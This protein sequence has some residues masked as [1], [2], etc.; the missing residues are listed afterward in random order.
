MVELKVKREIIYLGIL[1]FSLIGGVTII[2]SC[3]KE[4]RIDEQ[5]GGNTLTDISSLPQSEQAEVIQLQDS[6]LGEAGLISDTELN[7]AI[8]EASLE[9]F[10]ILTARAPIL[11]KYE[12]D[13]EEA[14]VKQEIDKELSINQI[15][16][17]FTS[18][19]IAQ[20]FEIIEQRFKDAD[21]LGE[22]YS[23]LLRKMV[24][25]SWILSCKTQNKLQS[26]CLA[27]QMSNCE[28]KILGCDLDDYSVSGTI[29]VSLNGSLQENNY[30]FSVSVF[31]VKLEKGDKSITFYGGQV[32]GEIA[33]DSTAKTGSIKIESR[34]MNVSDTE[35]GVEI[36]G[37]VKHQTQLSS[38]GVSVTRTFEN[39]KYKKDGKTFTIEGGKITAERKFGSPNL[40]IKVENLEVNTDDNEQLTLSG[41][42]KREVSKDPKFVLKEVLSQISFSS[43][44]TS[45]S[46]EF[47][48]FKKVQKESTQDDRTFSISITNYVKINDKVI[49]LYSHNLTI[50]KEG[51]GEFKVS[52]EIKI[53]KKDGT[54]IQIK[55]ENVKVVKGCQ[56]LT[57][58]TISADVKRNGKVAKVKATLSQNCSCEHEVEVEKD[59][60]LI[61]SNGNVCEAKKKVGKET[62]EDMMEEGKGMGM[63]YGS[64][65]HND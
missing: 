16:K 42:F 18:V 56:N 38:Y 47:Y 44:A 21:R 63:M 1:V 48:R 61:K 60:K 32:L 13:D 45:F 24:S 36:S 51:A 22:K 35:E 53:V 11:P 46:A 65:H 41:S 5:Q 40:T 17:N 26:S 6:L 49:K 19:E 59:G 39:I 29:N 10:N 20:K 4:T 62:M 64:Y 33:I 9:E 43:S 28:I 54:E 25:A 27:T 3:A 50:V 37:T 2:Q 34:N 7:P 52:G 8:I 58:G 55:L 23:S 15:I 12:A 30:S 57:G 14:E 31:N